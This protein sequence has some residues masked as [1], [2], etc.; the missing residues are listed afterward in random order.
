MTTQT[1]RCP[2]C[3]E[4]IN[5]EVK[6]GESSELDKTLERVKDMNIDWIIKQEAERI[7][8][9]ALKEKKDE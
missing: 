1:M 3:K 4:V 8:Q 6:V 5:V 7:V 2:Y 9:Q